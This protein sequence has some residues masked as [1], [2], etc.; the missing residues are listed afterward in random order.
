MDSKTSNPPAPVENEQHLLSSSPTLSTSDTSKQ[1]TKLPLPLSLPGLRMN[2]GIPAFVKRKFA[3]LSIFKQAELL[4]I[5]KSRF[6]RWL[7]LGDARKPLYLPPERCASVPPTCHREPCPDN[8]SHAFKSILES[9]PAMPRSRFQRKVRSVDGTSPL[10]SPSNFW[11]EGRYFTLEKVRFESNLDSI[12]ENDDLESP[13]LDYSDED[14]FAEQGNPRN[15]AD[16]DGRDQ[17]QENNRDILVTL[18]YT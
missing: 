3:A 5:T 9:P 12:N 17:Q 4:Q 13:D 2:G 11:L 7:K 16:E 14:V 18:S 1:A 8:F 10:T 15:G 6:A